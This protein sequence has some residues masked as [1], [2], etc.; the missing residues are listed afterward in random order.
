LGFSLNLGPFQTYL[1]SDNLLA[2]TQYD[3]AKFI[4]IRTGV[5]WN[6]GRNNDRDGDGVPNKKISALKNMALLN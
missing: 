5:N 3:E 6:F 4:N 1:F 2:V